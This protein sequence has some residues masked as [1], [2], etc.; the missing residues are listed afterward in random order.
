MAGVEKMGKG[1]SRRTEPQVQRRSS[2]IAELVSR[3]L[4]IV[5]GGSR[6]FERLEN[7]GRELV[8]GSK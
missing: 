7:A 4:L 1:L 3:M 5:S 8:S 2:E 6:V